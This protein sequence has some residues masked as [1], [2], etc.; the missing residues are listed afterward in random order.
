MWGA[1]REPMT[2]EKDNARPS[3]EAEVGA[4]A[5]G[6]PEQTRPAQGAITEAAA[7]E[8]ILIGQVLG[9][10]YRLERVLG[11]GGMG[12]LPGAR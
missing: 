7:P 10:R 2:E 5:G 1:E 11:E 3:S 6:A 8:A 4:N 9:G 12:G